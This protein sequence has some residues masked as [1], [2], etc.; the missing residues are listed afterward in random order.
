MS[1]ITDLY[2]DRGTDF[3]ATIRITDS[4]DSSNVNIAGAT[5]VSTIRKGPITSSIAGN[6][7]CAIV[8]VANGTIRMSIDS[9]NTANIEPGRYLYDV[10]KIDSEGNKSKTISGTVIVSPGISI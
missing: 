9:A 10:I 8:S 6:I 5:F 4:N 3:N 7:S 1:G 2:I